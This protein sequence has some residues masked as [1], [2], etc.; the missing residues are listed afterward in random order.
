[1][2][3]QVVF[4]SLRVAVASDIYHAIRLKIK[5]RAIQSARTFICS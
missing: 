3:V 1:M 4:R 5:E 2:A